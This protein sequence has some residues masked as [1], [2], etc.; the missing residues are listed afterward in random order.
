MV[1]MWLC[2]TQVATARNV[3]RELLYSVG[4]QNWFAVL[5][6]PHSFDIVWLGQSVIHR[7]K[8]DIVAMN[9]THF[10]SNEGA[11]ELMGAMLLQVVDTFK[12]RTDDYPLWL[13]ISNHCLSYHQ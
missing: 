8:W 9:V 10:V 5:T 3:V 1:Q 7:K 4:V 6:N 11:S 13:I 2:T 12:E